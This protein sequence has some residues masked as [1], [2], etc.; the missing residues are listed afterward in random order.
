MPRQVRI[1]YADAIY[2]VMA[3]GNRRGKIV[4]DDEDRQR[5]VRTLVEV[6]AKMVFMIS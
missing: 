2:H 5:F 1:E 6:V 4:L 3:R